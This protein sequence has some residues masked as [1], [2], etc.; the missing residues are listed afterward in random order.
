[1]AYVIIPSVVGNYGGRKWSAFVV[2]VISSIIIGTTFPASLKNEA[3]SE[4]ISH[5]KNYT[6]Q[7]IAYSGPVA[8]LVAEL[9]AYE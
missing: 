3:K 6:N 8:S 4:I 2:V 5:A 9:K 7:I 1:M